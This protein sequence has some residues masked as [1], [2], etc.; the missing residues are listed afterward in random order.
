MTESDQVEDVITTDGSNKLS[1]G[2]FQNSAMLS[3]LESRLE[4]LQGR[5]SSYIATLPANVRQRV[6]ALKN[7]QLKNNKIQQELEKKIL[8]LE[9]QFL[10]QHQVVY[11]KRSEIINGKYEP[12]AE[13]AELIHDEDELPPAPPANADIKG[14]PE[15]WLTCLKNVP[16]L[17]ENITEKDEAALKHLIDIK[18]EY[19]DNNPGFVLKFY[20]SPNEYFTNSVLEKEYH[21]QFVEDSLEAVYDFAK[22]TK[23]EWKQDKD[24]SV[25]VEIKKQRH[26][27]TNKTR[28]V[29]KTVPCET[30]F[31]FFNP[32]TPPAD[33]D[34]LDDEELEAFEMDYDIGELI[35]DRVVP[36]AIDWFTGKALEEYENENEDGKQIGNSR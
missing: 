7:L 10:A 14:I 22:G 12:T 11:D 34:E 16:P 3:A 21:L 29:K 19:L 24:L 25:T 18:Y 5:P 17:T 33:E 36:N 2:A 15:F 8:E 31:N 23:I 30:F 1:S 32:P 26:K 13:E 27:A 6:D 9:K 35:K 28:T 20:F 4:T